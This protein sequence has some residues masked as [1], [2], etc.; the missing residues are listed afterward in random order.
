MNPLSYIGQQLVWPKGQGTLQTGGLHRIARA[1]EANELP[2]LLPTPSRLLPPPPPKLQFFHLSPHEIK[3]QLSQAVSFP[4]GPSLKV[5]AQ[6]HVTVVATGAVKSPT[7]FES[8]LEIQ[9][10][11]KSL[12][13]HL[14]V[15]KAS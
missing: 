1:V 7:D 2:S 3:I 8:K 9:V 15:S 11:L 12:K 4:L 5:A 14:L 6:I 13:Q 10:Q